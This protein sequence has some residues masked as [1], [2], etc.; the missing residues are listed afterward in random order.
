MILAGCRHAGWIGLDARNR[1]T[2]STVAH[3]HGMRRRVNVKAVRRHPFGR[4]AVRHAFSIAT[5][6]WNRRRCGWLPWVVSGERN[7]NDHETRVALA[8]AFDL[9]WERFIAI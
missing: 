4:G 2:S 8:R 3:D 9:A 5:P 1:L 7:L 6:E